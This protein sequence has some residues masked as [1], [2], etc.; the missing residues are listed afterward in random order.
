MVFVIILAAILLIMLFFTLACFMTA[1]YSSPKR[2]EDP[3]H[4]PRSEQYQ[5]VA[6]GILALVENVESYPFEWVHI[7]SYDGLDLAARYYHVKDGAPVIISFHGF[8][9]TSYRDCAGIFKVAMELGFNVLLPDMRGHGQSQG[10]V[11]TLGIRERYDA[12]SWVQYV[13]DR[14]GS[15][16]RIMLSGCSMGAATVMMSAELMPPQVKGIA[17]DCGYSTPKAIMKKVCAQMHM[18]PTLAY[19]FL[20]LSAKT[21]GHFDPDQR[22]SVQSLANSKIPALFVHGEDDNYVPCSMVQE[23]YDACAADIKMLLTVPGAGHGLSFL[24]DEPA[25]RQA[26]MEFFKKIEFI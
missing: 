3:H 24:V 13:L 1:Y 16:T 9:S 26:L 22:S 5:Q 6:D 25:Y 23:N 12:L 17:C 18:Q 4:I 2:K 10:R 14:F 11:I 21:L 8:R 19:F 20:R 7:K 15:D